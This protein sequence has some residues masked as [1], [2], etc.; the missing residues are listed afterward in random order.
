MDKEYISHMVDDIFDGNN[1]DARD[2]F[3]DII[4]TKIS[5]ALD[6]RKIDLSQTI[7]NDESQEE[8]QE[9]EEETEE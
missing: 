8:E 9:S 4:S 2:K 3:E 7:F 6:Q 1:T 5:N